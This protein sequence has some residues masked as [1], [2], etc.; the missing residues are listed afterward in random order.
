MLEMIVDT[1][2][3]YLTQFSGQA[4]HQLI[5]LKGYIIDQMLIVGLLQLVKQCS[6]GCDP[7]DNEENEPQLRKEK[8]HKGSETASIVQTGVVSAA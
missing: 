3:E 1:G 5:T 4:N 8:R 2:C 7:S 6:T